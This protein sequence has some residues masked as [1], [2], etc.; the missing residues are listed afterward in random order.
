MG[1]TYRKYPITKYIYKGHIFDEYDDLKDL[2]YEIKRGVNFKEVFGEKS[3][4][5]KPWFK[6]DKTFKKISKKKR[7]AEQRS[8]FIKNPENIPEHKKTDGWDYI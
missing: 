5:S 2:P 4:D 3:R 6:P 7:K 1:K 8:A